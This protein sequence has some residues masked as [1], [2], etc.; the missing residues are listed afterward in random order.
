M[1]RNFYWTFPMGPVP[2]GFSRK[3]GIN[4]LKPWELNPN[5]VRRI[6]QFPLRAF[7][8]GLTFKWRKLIVLLGITV[9]KARLGFSPLNGGG[10]GGK[11]KRF[12]TGGLY[13]WAFLGTKFIFLWGGACTALP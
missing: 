13:T 3:G 8:L 5:L 10:L 4:S 1:A 11:L 9:R 7:T 12:S 2:N 6:F